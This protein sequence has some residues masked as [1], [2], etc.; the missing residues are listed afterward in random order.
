MQRLDALTWFGGTVTLEEQLRGLSFALAEAKGKTV[1]DAGC[2]EG[3]IGREFLKAGAVRV[4]AFDHS[5]LMVAAAR[6]A[7]GEGGRVE[8]HNVSK[9]FPD[10]MA[11]RYDIV[12][13]LAI[14]HKGRNVAEIA[15]R[16]AEV[17]AN[18]LVVRLPRNS[19][20]EFGSKHWPDDRVDLE[21]DLPKYGLRLERMEK[22]PK[23]EW[24]QYWR[25]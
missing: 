17:T 12:L 18:L 6:S 21:V 1:L 20:G 13:A 10:W 2:A 14:I 19:K 9:P 25:R 23:N 3:W 15:R 5:D 4:D 11:A 22:G 8:L 7:L 16:F 24:V